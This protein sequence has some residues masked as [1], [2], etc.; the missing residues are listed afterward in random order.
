LSE[1]SIPDPVTTPYG[2]AHTL[3][4][5]KLAS[6]RSAADGFLAFELDTTWRN[7]FYLGR[8]ESM[9]SEMAGE[10][11]AEIDKILGR[12]TNPLHREAEF[13]A[14]VLKHGAKREEELLQFF[15]KRCL[16]QEALMGPAMRELL[17]VQTVL[18]P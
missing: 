14:F 7:A 16:R 15:Q 6:L 1:P 9:W 10:E 18:I 4:V 12:V 2:S 11:A 5:D 13:E 8:V 17:D 3:L